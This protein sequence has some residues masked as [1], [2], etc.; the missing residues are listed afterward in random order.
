[1]IFGCGIR[2]DHWT[3]LEKRLLSIQ[4]NWR[5]PTEIYFDA[6]VGYDVFG[7]VIFNLV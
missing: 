2:I 6:T 3:S 4:L 7:V 1:M 5:N